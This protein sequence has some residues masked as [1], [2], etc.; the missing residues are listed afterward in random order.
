MSDVKDYLPYIVSC[1]TAGLSFLG[2]LMINRRS[3]KQEIE[4]LKMEHENI[5]ARNKQE[6]DAKI[7]ALEKE[8]ALKAG[9]QIVTDF[10]GK[11]IDAVFSSEAVKQE[12]NKQSF[13]SFTSKKSGGGRKKR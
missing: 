2:S 4:K 12:I 3:N 8:Y 11:T 10:A 13:K 1:V 5:M 7:A 9:T 6:Q